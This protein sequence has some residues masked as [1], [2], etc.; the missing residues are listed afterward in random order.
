M[1]LKTKTLALA[2]L[3]ASGESFVSNPMRGPVAS[4]TL[5]GTRLFATNIVPSQ[6][7]GEVQRLREMAAKLRQEAANLEADQRA[8]INV[9][10]ERVFRKF[11]TDKNGEISAKE[12]KSGL[13]K[14]FKMDLPDQRA[15]QLVKQFDTNGDGSL[16]LEEFVAVDKFR[17][18]LD[19][20]ARQE[21]E[22]AREKAKNERAQEEA[23]ALAEARMEIVNDNPPTTG[24]KLVS[25][26]PY[27][28]PLLDGLQFARFFVEGNQDNPLA[29][30]ATVAYALYRSIPLGGLLPFL[31]LTFL[32]ENPKLNRLVR[33]NLQQAV[34]LDIF[35]F[36]PAL[37][38]ALGAALA[39]QFGVTI[40]A[41]VTELSNDAM[42]LVLLT[43]IGYATV[44]SLF[45][46]TPNMLPFISESVENRMLSADMFDEDGRFAPFDEEGN[47]KKQNKKDGNSD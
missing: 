12:L 33:F 22:L 5:R 21:R 15:D 37:V 42:F 45:G 6:T 16:Q 47:L 39:G 23:A 18:T 13:E 40:P 41:A 2:L 29:I 20:L 46:Q 44:S 1:N 9:A 36:A 17:N 32:S 31:G 25:V 7:E 27:L 30:A 3:A 35:L 24:D 19:A 10:A 43:S 34:S 38:A 26:L 4:A 8:A 14:I 28:F 11:D